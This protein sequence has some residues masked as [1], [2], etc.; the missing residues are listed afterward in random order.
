[1]RRIGKRQRRFCMSEIQQVHIHI[2]MYM[3]IHIHI[4]VC[5]YI[6]TGTIYKYVSDS[7]TIV[8]TYNN[9]WKFAHFCTYTC[10]HTC[11]QTLALA[12]G[13][14]SCGETR[15]N[16]AIWTQPVK[17]KTAR[18]RRNVKGRKVPTW[19][20]RMLA[21]EDDDDCFYYYKK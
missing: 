15:T 3:C 20:P 1:V 9:T 8:H 19:N 16:K 2:H 21:L 12:K 4:C 17:K 14:G 5:I 13:Q 7:D 10:V 6:H 18:C 11:T